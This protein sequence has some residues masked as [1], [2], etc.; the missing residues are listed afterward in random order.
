MDSLKSGVVRLLRWSEKYTK[1]DMVYLAKGGFW[2]V[3][4]QVGSVLL[5]FALAVAFGH[6]AGQDTYGNY[7]YV[8]SLAGLFTAF[9][10]TGIGTA[11]T[12]ATARG[13]E[14]SLRQGARL[15]L[16][17]G[18]GVSVLALAVAG[19][20]FFFEHDA[21]LA[22]ALVIVA[23]CMPLMNAYSLF[24]S[25]LNGKKDFTRS[26]IY[27]VLNAALPT[28]IL[29]AALFWTDRAIVF[30]I[31]YF[32]ANTIADIIAH[33]TTLRHAKNEEQDP[34][35]FLYGT[36]LSVMGIV[37]TIASKI[38]SV[39]VF[40]LLGPVQLAIYAYAAAI[41]EQIKGGIKI[42]GALAMPKFSQRTVSEIKATIWGRIF[43]LTAALACAVLVYV[44]LA[45]WIFALFFP[46]YMDSIWYSQLYAASIVFTGFVTPLTAILQA[47]RKTRELYF[48]TS[49]GSVTLIIL[50]P[51]L[52]FFWGILGAV[53]SQILYRAVNAGTAIILTLRLQDDQL[54]S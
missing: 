31:T 5:S 24:G 6:L 26:S 36:H 40:I 12:Q 34:D 7:K 35:I 39:S 9:S 46:V 17:W 25:F 10:L 3:L 27:G 28:L 30:I 2:L 14:G 41:P 45:H 29:I 20:Y 52:T 1:T 16:K 11:V 38:D 13:Y 48:A 50:L 33:I 32:V 51:V 22:V 15:S 4:A 19:Y 49:V 37:N 23:V 42:I 47:Q 43:L 21:F 44:G 53:I 8:I 54:L 18:W